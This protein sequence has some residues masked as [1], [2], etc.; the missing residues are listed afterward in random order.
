MTDPSLLKTSIKHVLPQQDDPPGCEDDGGRDLVG[1]WSPGQL[2][3]PGLVVFFTVFKLNQ[4]ERDSFAFS[5]F[6]ILYIL[7]TILD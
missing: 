2:G 6:F 1:C 3:E 5:I 7:L 4:E